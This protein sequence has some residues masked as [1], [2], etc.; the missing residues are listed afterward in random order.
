ML[1]SYPKLYSLVYYKSQNHG[2]KIRTNILSCISLYTHLSKPPHDPNQE[3]RDSGV[4]SVL[5]RRA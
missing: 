1:P 5:Q 3:P 4:L 2:L